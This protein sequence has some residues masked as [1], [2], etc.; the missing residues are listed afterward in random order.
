MAILTERVR[1]D[2]YPQA[3]VISTSDLQQARE[4]ERDA[5]TVVVNSRAPAW[6]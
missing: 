6:D 5:R 1:V 2:L 4:M 3:A